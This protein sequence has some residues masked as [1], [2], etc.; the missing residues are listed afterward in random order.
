MDYSDMDIDGDAYKAYVAGANAPL[1]KPQPGPRSRMATPVIKPVVLPGGRILDPR[2]LALL[3]PNVISPSRP[4]SLRLTVRKVYSPLFRPS[5]VVEKEESPKMPSSLRKRSYAEYDDE[6][7]TPASMPEEISIDNARSIPGMAFDIYTRA[8]NIFTAMYKWFTIFRGDPQ[9]YSITVD[10]VETS[11]GS[12]KRRAVQAG[13]GV[14]ITEFINT[15]EVPGNYPAL[16]SAKPSMIIT[17]PSS[18]PTSSDGKEPACEQKPSQQK[19]TS[20]PPPQEQQQPQ[21]STSP[22]QVSTGPAQA[23][24]NDAEPA[25]FR[26]KKPL[27]ARMFPDDPYY[28]DDGQQRARRLTKLIKERKQAEAER[29]AQEAKE[30]PAPYVTS[31]QRNLMKKQKAAERKDGD[32]DRLIGKAKDVAITSPDAGS[33]LEMR[34]IARA[35]RDAELKEKAAREEA[36]RK[37][38]AAREKAEQKEKAAREEAEL[39]AEWALKM[40][41]LEQNAA[42]TVAAMNE[43]WD[44]HQAEEK[45]KAAII[46]PLTEEWAACLET[47]MKFKSMEHVITQSPDGADL[48][49]KD[50]G[51]LLAEVKSDSTD[52]WL[53]DEIVNAWLSL[54]VTR[55]HEKTGYVKSAKAVPNFVAYNSAWL[56][57]VKAKGMEGIAGWSRRKGIKGEKLLKAEKIFFPINTG[58]H[59]M[60]LVISPQD[61]KLDFLDSLDT[62]LSSNRTTFMHKA[63]AWLAMELGKAYKAEEW[64]ETGAVSSQQTNGNDCGAFACFNALASASGKEYSEVLAKDMQNGRRVMGAALIGFKGAFD[65]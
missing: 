64:K 47:E 10:A 27:L 2:V 21:A 59:W 63:R 17:P 24:K 60:M 57:T 14:N 54:I 28:A 46:K 6:D 26:E 48:T 51:T 44:Q 45:A 62:G 20:T 22:T 36:E 3:K 12:S 43:K 19:Q 61:K 8:H 29:A 15:H 35:K 9:S 65:V 11:P 1:P 23:T 34:R 16:S 30:S 42:H 53:N 49:R 40:V 4:M 18:R 7:N 38:K 13:A 33:F 52:A 5:H 50:F 58:A 31:R 56:T 41:E 37:Q 39:E 55:K 32:I 25:P